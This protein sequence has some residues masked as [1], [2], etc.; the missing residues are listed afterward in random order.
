MKDL[1]NYLNEFASLYEGDAFGLASDFELVAGISMNELAVKLSDE[2]ESLKETL[3]LD[4][5]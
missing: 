3:E 2:I 4:E 1:V 5:D